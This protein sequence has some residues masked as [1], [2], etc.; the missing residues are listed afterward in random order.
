MKT[1]YLL[2]ALG[3]LCAVVYSIPDEDDEPFQNVLKGGN[4][5][6][7]VYITLAY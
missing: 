5:S 4:H 3:L 7:I 1:L 2:F 6:S